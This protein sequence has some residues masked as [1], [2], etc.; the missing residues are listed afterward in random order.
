MYKIKIIET[1][2]FIC[3]IRTEAEETVDNSN[4]QIKIIHS[5][6][7]DTIRSKLRRI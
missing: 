7:V 2:C 6:P 1:D 4:I 5:E 3:E